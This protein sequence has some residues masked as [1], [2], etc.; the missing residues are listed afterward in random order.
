MINIRIG[1]SEDGKRMILSMDGHA[2]YAEPGKDIVCAGATMLA[3]ALGQ[4]LKDFYES[5]F[6]RHE[7]RLRYSEGAISIEA[8]PKK[9]CFGAVHI[10]FWCTLSGCRLL[11]HRYPEYVR[12]D[13]PGVE[14]P[15]NGQEGTNHE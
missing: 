12:L 5:G 9:D 4:T 7:P 14:S 3:Y 13:Q 15:T 11:E 2:G 6:L 1:Y 10:A 8:A